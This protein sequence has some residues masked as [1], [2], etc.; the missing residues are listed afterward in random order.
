MLCFFNA[1]KCARTPTHPAL[2]MMAQRTKYRVPILPF[3]SVC[4]QS[5]D[6]IPETESPLCCR[7]QFCDNPL[8]FSMQPLLAGSG[9]NILGS[10]GNLECPPAGN[11]MLVIR[12]AGLS[13]LHLGRIKVGNEIFQLKEDLKA[14]GNDSVLFFE[15]P[16]HV[17]KF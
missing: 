16:K 3:S 12:G 1:H 10:F 13:N 15:Q 14:Y 4:P 17:G 9:C 6:N 7:G 8:V 5:T 11:A 2:C